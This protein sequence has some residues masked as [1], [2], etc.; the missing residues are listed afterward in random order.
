MVPVAAG[1]WLVFAINMT[2]DRSPRSYLNWN[3]LNFQ[4]MAI[5]PVNYIGHSSFMFLVRSY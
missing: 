4:I 1:V 5:N 2:R 3:Y